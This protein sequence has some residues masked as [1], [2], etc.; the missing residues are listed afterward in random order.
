MQ[1]PSSKRKSLED[2]INDPET[3][4]FVHKQVIPRQ[5]DISTGQHSNI[6]TRQHVDERISVSVKVPKRI[7]DALWH[8]MHDRTSEQKNK[9]LAPGEPYEKQDIVSQALE[10]WLNDKGYLK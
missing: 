6:L 7:A 10:R 2:L 1:N 3:Q 5:S 8:A 9:T 4:A